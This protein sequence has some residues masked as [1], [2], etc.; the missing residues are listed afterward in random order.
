M[1]AV[2]VRGR[3]HSQK[4]VAGLFQIVRDGN[5]LGR[6]CGAADAGPADLGTDDPA[7]LGHLLTAGVL[8]IIEQDLGTS[9]RAPTRRHVAC[10]A[11]AARSAGQHQHC[12]EDLGGGSAY[13]RS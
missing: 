1:A 8:E 2:A 9:L 10:D 4:V 11:S 6:P 5:V 7:A 13:T 3:R 12:R